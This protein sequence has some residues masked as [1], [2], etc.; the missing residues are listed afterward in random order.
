M[1][2][3][4][5]VTAR[6]CEKTFEQV[7]IDSCK[8]LGKEAY[9]NVQTELEEKFATCCSDQTVGSLLLL[10]LNHPVQ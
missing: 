6:Y 5:I 7:A 2:P 3:L 1:R 10:L 9:D 8:L 4:L